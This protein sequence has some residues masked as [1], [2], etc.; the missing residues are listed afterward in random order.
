MKNFLPKLSII[1]AIFLFGYTTKAQTA[2][3]NNRLPDDFDPKTNTLLIQKIGWSKTQE[4][5]LENYLKENYPFKYKLID[6][7]D[8]TDPASTYAD[9]EIYGFVLLNE[10]K[11]KTG[12]SSENQATKAQ[13]SYNQTIFLL[14]FYD[15]NGR[16][17]YPA[18]DGNRLTS[19][20]KKVIEYIAEKFK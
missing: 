7:K 8:I 20:L 5:A 3:T 13:P 17:H 4:K 15:R 18:F 1:A 10:V 2:Q 6:E 9:T 11:T 12:T 19:P 14:H 16:I